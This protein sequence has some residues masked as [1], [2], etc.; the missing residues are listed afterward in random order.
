MIAN[1]NGKVIQIIGLHDPNLRLNSTKLLILLNPKFKRLKR[2]Q[3]KG[4]F[5]STTAGAN[6]VKNK[7]YNW[8]KRIRSTPLSTG[9]LRQVGIC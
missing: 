5:I 4:L 1:P 2:A 7:N 3:K 8:H 6:Q 9:S